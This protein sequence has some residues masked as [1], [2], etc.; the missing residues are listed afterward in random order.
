MDLTAHF[1]PLVQ[2]SINGAPLGSIAFS[3]LSSVSVSDAVGVSSDTCEIEFANTGLLGAAA[4]PEPG[5]EISIA[6]GYLGKFVPVGVFVADE[7][8]ESAPPRKIVVT[9]RAKAQTETQSGLAP[10]HQHKTRSW[11]AGMALGAIVDTI[12]GENGLKPGAT[13]AAAAIVP[14][15]LDQ[16][17][18]S[19]L[20][21][22]TRV[23]QAHDLI[24]K[25]A[26]GVLFVGARADSVS[27]SGKPLPTFML[28]QASVTRWSMRRALGD[29]V[30]TVI[31]TYRDLEKAEDVEVE[32]GEG[33]PAR[34]LT[35]RFRDEDSATQAAEVEARRSS[36]AR[37]SLEVTM[38][39][40]PG[41][42]A[43]CRVVPLDFSGATSGEWVVKSATHSVTAGGYVTSFSAERPE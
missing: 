12:A 36:R 4:M 43:E 34:R 33:E 18:E 27:A 28:R 19:D 38:P 3:R 13:E 35:E 14:G 25:P 6:L 22:L 16:I 2:V 42:G 11:P 10:I 32:V 39:G 1:R 15:H 23:A 31:A 8:E 17:D 37:E 29:M 7:V 21:L 24:A 26:G 20:S 41:L 30:G 9:G 40:R 5:A